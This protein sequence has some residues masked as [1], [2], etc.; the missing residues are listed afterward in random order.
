MR[1][2]RRFFSVLFFL[3]IMISGNTW[4]QKPHRIISLAPSITKQLVLLGLEEQIVGITTYCEIPN[5]ETYEIVASAVDVNLEKVIT[6]KPDLVLATSLSKPESLDILRN[7]GINVRYL[8]LPKSYA[9]INAQFIE[10]GQLCGK[11]KKA[12]EIVTEQEA[13]MKQLLEKVNK[14]H[15]PRVFFEIGTNPLWCVI[16]NTFMNDFITMAGG[17]NI[18]GDLKMGSISRESV[19]LRDPEIIIIAT[20]GNVGAD[21]ANIWKTYSNLSA[22]KND[23][24][25]VVDSDRSCSPTPLHFVETLEEI[26]NFMYTEKND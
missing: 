26:I 21:E 6:M 23:K 16:P 4:A 12:R 24:I 10:L 14:N 9:E 25:L 19:I 7:T 8:N 3:I 2:N 18:A 13:R 20:M 17:K 22:V 11:E 1:P 5:K 15:M